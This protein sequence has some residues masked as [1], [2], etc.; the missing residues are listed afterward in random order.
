MQLRE[1]QGDDWLGRQLARE[2]FGAARMPSP[3][4]SCGH[5]LGEDDGPVGVGAVRMATGRHEPHGSLCCLGWA[6]SRR[7]A[8]RI[9]PRRVEPTCDAELRRASSGGIVTLHQSC[10][11]VHRALRER[12]PFHT[13]PPLLLQMLARLGSCTVFSFAPPERRTTK[14][15]LANGGLVG[16]SRRRATPIQRSGDAILRDRWPSDADQPHSNRAASD[17]ALVYVGDA[18]I[19]L[20]VGRP[21]DDSKRLV[22]RHVRG[23]GIDPVDDLDNFVRIGSVVA[24]SARR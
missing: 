2:K 15:P 24:R 10:P 11:A 7:F 3:T 8:H 12:E 4:G 14:I 20:T 6:A 9:C 18:T 21:D 5:G 1:R 13:Q 16:A 22:R 19:D 23:R 17:E